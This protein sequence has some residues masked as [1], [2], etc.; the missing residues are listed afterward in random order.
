MIRRFARFRSGRDGRRARLRPRPGEALGRGPDGR[1]G[2]RH[3]PRAVAGDRQ[4]AQGG[5]RPG[6]RGRDRARRGQHLPRP[7]GR[8][9]RAWTARPRTTWACSRSCSTP[10][11]SRTRSRRRAC[12]RACSR[13]SRS[14]RS[15]SRTSAAAP[16]AT[17]RRAAIVIFAA[18]TGN[19]FFTSDTA[20]ALRAL[21]MHAE[22]ILMAKNGVEGVYTADPKKDPDAEF[23]PEITAREAIQRGLQGDGLDGAVAVHGQPPADQRLQHERRVQHRPDSLRRAG[24]DAGEDRNDRRP[25]QRRPGAHGQVRGCD[26]DEVRLGPDRPRLAGAA[27][28]HQR[29]LLRRCDAAQAAR[30]GLG[31]GGAA[32]DRAAVRQELDQEH[33]AGDPGVRHRAHAQ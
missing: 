28:P 22:A 14:P 11:R 10:S 32:S 30:H 2:V 8:G 33:R 16:C 23:I 29:R 18:G 26:A 5:A 3:R 25:S 19:P 31:A 4:A 1:S 12:T 27:G 9:G 7:R 24:G 17:W 21:E 6:R 15:P 13:R 20:A